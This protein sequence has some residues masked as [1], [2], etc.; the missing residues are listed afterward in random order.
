MAGPQWNY[1]N[2]RPIFKAIETYIPINPANFNAAERGNNGPT[3]VRQQ[4]ATTFSTFLAP[5]IASLNGFSPLLRND[6][7]DGINLVI[8]PQQ[9]SFQHPNL[10]R[11]FGPDF[12]L[13]SIVNNAGQGINGRRVQIRSNAT[14]AKVIFEMN[15]SNK[16]VIKDKKGNMC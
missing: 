9:Q 16:R 4:P 10:T 3:S 1:N 12:F 2:L 13:N 5:V 7:N 6:Y 8:S 14:V 15:E 11:S